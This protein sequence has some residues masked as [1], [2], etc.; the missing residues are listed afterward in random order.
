MH[1]H[2]CLSF[3]CFVSL[4]GWFGAFLKQSFSVRVS[5]CRLGS[6]NT[7][8]VNKVDPPV[9]AS[10]VLVVHVSSPP[11]SPGDR[12]FSLKVYSPPPDS[13]VCIQHMFECLYRVK[14]HTVLM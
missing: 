6:H 12:C 8:F 4:V 3:L 2:T 11:P 9:S 1:S 5:L 13:F 14:T 10:K 7:H